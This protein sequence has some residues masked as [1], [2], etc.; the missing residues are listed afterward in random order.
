MNLC[1]NA[2]IPLYNNIYFTQ[3]GQV[4]TT[5]SS[6]TGT[7]SRATLRVANVNQT[8]AVYAL[9]SNTAGVTIKNIQ[10]DG[11]RPALGWVQ[12]GYA[13]FEIG[14]NGWNQVVSNVHAYEPR[15]W[16]TIVSH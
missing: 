16:S 10:V 3:P 12:G 6:S 11:S 8:C 7:E 14:G 1:P 5:L 15:G 2:V 9:G 13:L 4:L